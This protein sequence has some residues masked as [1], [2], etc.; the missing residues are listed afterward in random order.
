MAKHT[1]SY[2]HVMVDWQHGELVEHVVE[3]PTCDWCGEHYTGRPVVSPRGLCL[4]CGHECLWKY[5]AEKEG[6]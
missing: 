4:F 6:S 2:F 5:L 1:E 3:A